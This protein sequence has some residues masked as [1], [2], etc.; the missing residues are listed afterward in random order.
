MDI[1][2]YF[3]P[4]P[5]LLRDIQ[6]GIY[7]YSRSAMDLRLYFLL[8][9]FTFN[10]YPRRNINNKSSEDLRFYFQVITSAVATYLRPLWISD[11]ISF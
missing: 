1:R 10:T 11:C 4:R 8:V 7:I 2:L 5:S 6:K 9:P 3:L